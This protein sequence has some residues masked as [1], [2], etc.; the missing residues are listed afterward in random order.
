VDWHILLAGI[1]TEG[2]GSETSWEALRG[3]VGQLAVAVLAGYP[4]APVELD[5]LIQDV[6]VKLQDPRRLAMARATRNPEN[7]LAVLM[8]NHIRDALRRFAIELRAQDAFVS[9]IM[10]E[11]TPGEERRMLSAEI[12]DQLG[13]EDRKLLILRYWC[14]LTVPEIAERLGTSRST[15]SV[16]LHRVI[17]RLRAQQRDPED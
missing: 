5:D 4:N 10:V 8:R 17:A 3:A 11:P 2:A 12:L 1:E 15:I 9:T 6:M 7:Y 13:P 14:G 16:R